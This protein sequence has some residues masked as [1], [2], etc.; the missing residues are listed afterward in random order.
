MFFVVPGESTCVR[1]SANLLD[2]TFKITVK[3]N[4]SCMQPLDICKLSKQDT[5]YGLR[6]SCTGLSGRADMRWAVLHHRLSTC[7]TAY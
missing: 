1:E 2:N 5:K 3:R 7:L 4:Q 6:G